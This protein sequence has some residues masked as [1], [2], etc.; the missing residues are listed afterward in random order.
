MIVGWYVREVGGDGYS[1]E[2]YLIGCIFGGGIV[3]DGFNKID[4]VCFCISRVYFFV[5]K[6]YEFEIQ[7]KM[8]ICFFGVRNFRVKYIVFEFGYVDDSLVRLSVNV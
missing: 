1:C 5:K 4:V 2:Q 7:Y 6:E 3:G 8:G